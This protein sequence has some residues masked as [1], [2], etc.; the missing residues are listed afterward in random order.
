MGHRVY[1][2]QA[3]LRMVLSKEMEQPSA[4]VSGLVRTKK[5]AALENTMR[6]SRKRTGGQW[7]GRK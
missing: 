2:T 4:L 5:M 7:E 1:K 6:L 3:F